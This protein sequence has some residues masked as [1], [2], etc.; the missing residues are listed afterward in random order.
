MQI[1]EG[2]PVPG[3]R[4]FAVVASRFNDS[5]T[6]RLVD[7]CVETL[8][9]RGVPEEDVVLAW[10]PG[11]F[12]I[13]LA[14]RR[15]AATGRY[16]AVVCLGAVIR[17]ETLHFEL[18]CREAAAGIAAASRDTGV[19]CV[20]EVLSTDTEEQ[21]LARA[22]GK[23]GNRGADAA[24]VALEMADLLPRLDGGPKRKGG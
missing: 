24:L 20:F 8:R 21:A 14:A 16:A 10:V 17:G 5:V 23:E 2:K 15:L 3:G 1:H 13:P 4:R 6:R 7:G 18:V 11:A 19:P 12:E 22:G 9:G